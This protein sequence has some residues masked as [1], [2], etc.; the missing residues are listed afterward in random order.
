MRREKAIDLPADLERVRVRF[1]RWRRTRKHRTAIPESL[2][3]AAAET[4]RRH[5]IN[6]VARTLRVDYYSLKER[7]ECPSFLVREVKAEGPASFLELPV[8]A[9]GT[10]CECVLEL[11]DVVG[12]TMRIE[13]KGVAS[14][15]LAALTRSFRRAES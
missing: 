12:T 10:P 11:K 5:G 2:W 14:P 6:R 1:A 9:R 13:L 3:T 15:D 8:P 7:A 4:A